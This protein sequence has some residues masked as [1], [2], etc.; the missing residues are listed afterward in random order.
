MLG[1]SSMDVSR[2]LN[3]SYILVNDNISI[4]STGQKSYVLKIHITKPTTNGKKVLNRTIDN[5]TMI[6]KSD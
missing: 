5:T 1:I 2:F 4:T 6:S 3:T